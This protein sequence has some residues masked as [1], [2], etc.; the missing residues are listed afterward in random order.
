MGF[1][2]FVNCNVCHELFHGKATE[3]AQNERDAI[4]VTMEAWR[5]DKEG[6]PLPAYVVMA[7]DFN[8]GGYTEGKSSMMQWS[9]K[10]CR[11]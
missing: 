3:R 9:E 10:V 1:F 5:K 6:Q 7:G 8:K 4:L 11:S 2:V